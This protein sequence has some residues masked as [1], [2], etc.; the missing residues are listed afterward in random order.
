[1]EITE[2]AYLLVS[3]IVTVVVNSI[4]VWLAGRSLVGSEKAKFSDAVGL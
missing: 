3:V 4:V 2:I 1:M